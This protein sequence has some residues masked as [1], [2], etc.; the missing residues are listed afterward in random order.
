MKILSLLKLRSLFITAFLAF[1]FVQS[2]SAQCY[3]VTSDYLIRFFADHGDYIPARQGPFTE[4]ECKYW[5]TQMDEWQRKE[6]RCDCPPK[7]DNQGSYDTRTQSESRIKIPDRETQLKRIKE[8]AHQKIKEKENAD[9]QIVEQKKQYLLGKLKRNKSLDQLKTASMLS[10]KGE[11]NVNNNRTEEGRD[12]S[13]SAFTEGRI[14]PNNSGLPDYNITVSPPVFIEH[15]QTLY[16]Y[17]DEQKKVVQTKITKVQKEKAEIQEKKNQSQEKI[18]VQSIGIKRLTT[19]KFMA[20]EETQKEEIDSLLM[21]ANQ[22]LEES[23]EQNEKADRELEEK[24]KLLQE[25]DALL[26]KYDEAYNISKEHPEK[27]DQLLKELRG[28]K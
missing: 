4:D 15:Q 28:D 18:K 21:L 13:E 2:L 9:R 1:Q 6:S 10:L 23:I 14:D 5:L 8:Y 12:D 7:S 26:N 17:I 16:E 27:S 24:N 3:M 19:E 22:L 20:K 11:Q 25:H